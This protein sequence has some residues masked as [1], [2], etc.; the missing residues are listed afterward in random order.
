[1]ANDEYCTCNHG[2]KAAIQRWVDK[3]GDYSSLYRRAEECLLFSGA[4]DTSVGRIERQM[5]YL[6]RLD[7][8]R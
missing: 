2:A 7:G 6:I 4:M 3:G 5:A 1:M 8:G